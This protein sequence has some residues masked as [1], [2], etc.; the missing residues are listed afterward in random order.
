MIRIIT[1]LLL[2]LLSQFTDAQGNFEKGMEQA[3]ALMQE[4][5]ALSR[6]MMDVLKE[7]LV[8]PRRQRVRTRPRH[9]TGQEG[10]VGSPGRRR[11]PAKGGKLSNEIA[12]RHFNDVT[13]GLFH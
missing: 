8:R 12:H 5:K 9:A 2:L 6:E 13:G 3:F 7:S 1:V 4:N 11:L 10:F